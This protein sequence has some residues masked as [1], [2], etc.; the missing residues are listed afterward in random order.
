ME[1]KSESVFRAGFLLRKMRELAEQAE[2]NREEL[3]HIQKE[4]KVLNEK[5]ES[6]MHDIS[7]AD[8]KPAAAERARTTS[9]VAKVLLGALLRPRLA[10]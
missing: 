4:A 9:A 6:V 3:K 7:H 8:S 5:W 10:H 1:D 2:A